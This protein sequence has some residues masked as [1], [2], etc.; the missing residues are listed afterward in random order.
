MRTRAW[1]RTMMDR[2]KHRVRMHN[3]YGLWDQFW[4]RR[5]RTPEREAHLVG[6]LASTRTPCSCWMCASPRKRGEITRQ[7]QRAL[8]ALR[9]QLI[10]SG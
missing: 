3:Y 6:R 4:L 2:W 9:E 8:V 7:E 1:R 5:G 10:D